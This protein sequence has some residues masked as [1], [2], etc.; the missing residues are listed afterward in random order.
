M[1]EPTNGGDARQQQT[2][3]RRGLFAAAIAA[4]AGM[5]AKVTEQ[6]V[7]A[8]DGGPVLISANNAGTGSTGVTSSGAGVFAL[9]GV[10]SGNAGN[11][12]GGAATGTGQAIG[13]YGSSSSTGGIGAYGV[14]DALSGSTVGVLGDSWSPSGI[15]VLGR[16]VRC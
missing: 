11:G 10:A 8:A 12:V 7:Q 4:V 5:V 14:D 3:K 9:Y 6:P 1:S 15:G 13:V 2:W 16:S